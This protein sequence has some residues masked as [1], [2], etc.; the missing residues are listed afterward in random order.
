MIAPGPT[1]RAVGATRFTKPVTAAAS[2]VVFVDGERAR[3]IPFGVVDAGD[4]VT[5]E[6]DVP[7]RHRRGGWALL[8]QSR[9]QRHIQDHR[10]RHFEA[11]AHAVAQLAESR[12]LA[13]VVIAGAPP[14]ATA[15]CAHLP[16]AL[17]ARVVGPIAASRHDSDAVIVKRVTH[18][19]WPGAEAE[20]AGAG[21]ARRTGGVK[22]RK[23]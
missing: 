22:G 2:L 15:F 9:Y 13:R 5:I 10:A 12:P 17:A 11:V 16:P 4:S 7:G 20:A 19:L 8:A 1:R 18:R 21:A 23:K 14:N 6:S 3:L